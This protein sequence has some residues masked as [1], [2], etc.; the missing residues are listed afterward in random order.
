MHIFVSGSALSTTKKARGEHPKSAAEMRTD[1]EPCETAVFL[2]STHSRPR[3]SC[4]PGRCYLRKGA[5]RR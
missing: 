3:R 4:T 5:F 1:V 2:L